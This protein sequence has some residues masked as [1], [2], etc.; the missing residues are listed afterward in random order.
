MKREQ[1]HNTLPT[2]FRL[3]RLDRGLR[4]HFSCQAQT[5]ILVAGVSMLVTQ[6]QDSA[7]FSQ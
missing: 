4:V 2:I 6:C 3:V 7:R 1:T 5:K